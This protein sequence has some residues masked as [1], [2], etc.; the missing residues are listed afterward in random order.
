VHSPQPHARGS[1]P[2][3]LR[4]I[5]YMHASIRCMGWRAALP[6]LSIVGSRSRRIV[7]LRH[8]RQVRVAVSPAGW[9]PFPGPPPPTAWPYMLRPTARLLRRLHAA[10]SATR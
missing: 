4:L 9:Q 1:R 3:L 7:A 10:P 8:T 2:H 5:I 6:R